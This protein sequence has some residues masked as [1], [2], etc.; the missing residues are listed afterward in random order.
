MSLHIE[1]E[2]HSYYMGFAIQHNPEEKLITQNGYSNNYKWQAYTDDGMYYTI[3]HLKSDSLA[4]LHEK[5]KDYHL[6]C[7]NW[8]AEQIQQGL[9]DDEIE[10]LE[11]SDTL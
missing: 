11:L 3:V 4:E 6:K 2:P 8:Y 10:K 1:F 7:N 5:I 9:S